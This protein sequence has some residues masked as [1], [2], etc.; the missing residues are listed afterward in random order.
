MDDDS[1]DGDERSVSLSAS[2]LTSSA[3]KVI[4][5]S[6]TT[7]AGFGKLSPDFDDSSFARNSIT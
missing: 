1:G 4:L 2:L 6:A 5:C 3:Q 7:P